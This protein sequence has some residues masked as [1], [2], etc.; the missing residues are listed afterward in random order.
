MLIGQ[1]PTIFKKDERVKHVLMSDDKNGQI[2][3][4]LKNMFG[5]ENFSNLEI[6]AP[7]LVK[8]SFPK[9]PSTMATGG[10]NFLKPYFENCQNYLR[11]ELLKFHPDLVISFGEP[12]HKLFS[13][14]LS[15]GSKKIT[16]QQDF[17]G[18]FKRMKNR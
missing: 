10:L 5:E 6:Y 4:W 17:T 16:M 8:C 13:Y 15:N 11:K 3:K 2:S 9:P 14:F 12:S 1:D 7:N 18:N